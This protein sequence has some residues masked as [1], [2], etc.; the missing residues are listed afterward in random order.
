MAT[1]LEEDRTVSYLEYFIETKCRQS[2]KFPNVYIPLCRRTMDDELWLK[3]VEV[4][5][6]DRTKR[7]KVIM[8]VGETGTGKTTTINSMLNF[9]MGVE[10]EDQFR[11]RLIEEEDEDDQ[12]KSVTKYITA[13]TIHQQPGFKTD[14]TLTIIDTPGFG[15]TVSMKRDEEIKGQIENFFSTEGFDG[16]DVL[17]AVGFVVKSN[18]PR[19]TL[20]QSYIFNSVLAVFGK[21]IQ[22]NIFMFCTFAS[23]GKKP[24]GVL[25][26]V[27]RASI[28]HSGY[29]KFNHEGLS[30]PDPEDFDEDE[31]KSLQVSWNLGRT[32][33]QNF[34]ARLNLVEPKSLQMTKDVLRGR[35]ELEDA[36]RNIQDNIMLG[37]NELEKLN[38]EKEVLKKYKE[39]MESNDGYVFQVNELFTEL[40][41]VPDGFTAINCKTCNV[42]CLTTRYPWKNSNLRDCWL[43]RGVSGKSNTT[44]C[45]KCPSKCEWNAHKCEEKY[46]AI[47]TK[48]ITKTLGELQKSYTDDE[49]RKMTSEQIIEEC[50]ERINEVGDETVRFVEKA[51][52]C[53]ERLDKIALKPDPLS[54]N[55]Y[56]DLMIEGEKARAGNE[57]TKRIQALMQLKERQEM[58]RNV[59]RG[60]EQHYLDMI[61][62]VST[63]RPKERKEKEEPLYMNM[64]G[65]S[66]PSPV[67]RLRSLQDLHF[68]EEDEDPIYD[69][70]YG[71]VST[72]GL[73]GKKEEEEP[74]YMNIQGSRVGT[75]LYETPVRRSRSLSAS[76][77]DRHLRESPFL[78]EED[79]E[80]IYEEIPY[81]ECNMTQV[82]EVERNQDGYK[83]GRLK[84]I[85]K[86]FKK[87][88]NKD[89][90]TYQ[91]LL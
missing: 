17:D 12:T 78:Q 2:E 10:F 11:L 31:I 19:L 39:D 18:S 49:G 91:K 76:L 32:N 28:P 6:K 27:N 90:H 13:Y 44:G 35:A 59:A 51:R 63:Q 79:E 47:N 77:Q 37:I 82:V 74:F 23:P 69:I 56:I 26:A 68:G 62:F 73:K 8:I 29:F 21:D 1:A 87:R 43:F 42:T 88:K 55:D 9:I 86:K 16:I 50:Q 70:P 84:K 52:G 46:I 89:V 34:F 5:R 72:Q 65:S 83:L 30:F 24:P 60:E 67:R 81:I 61:N 75:G 38:R 20:T 4:G 15:D 40:A 33:F 48:K 53:I 57:L 41:H 25:D 36:L 66:G 54:T 7:E 85:F 64:E 22:D 58:R 71:F 80:P 14:Y 45:H 3:K